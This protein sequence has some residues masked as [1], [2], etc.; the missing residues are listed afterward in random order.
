[1][2]ALLSAGGFLAPLL[3]PRKVDGVELGA[4]LRPGD[5]VHLCCGLTCLVKA[6]P[7]GKDSIRVQTHRTYVAN[8][9]A[10]GLFRPGRRRTTDRGRYVRDVW[11]V[12][13]TDF[14]G[15]LNH[16]LNGAEVGARQRKEGAVQSR[17]SRI[18]APWT[19]FDKEAA[20]SYPSVA[21][22]RRILT[23]VFRQSVDAAHEELT[24]MAMERRSLPRRRDHW[25]LPPKRKD[26][27]KLDQIGVDSAGNLVL[28]EVKEVA[29]AAP[30]EVYYAPFQLLQNVWEWHSGLDAVRGSVQELYDVGVELGMARAGAPPLRGAFDRPSGSGTTC[31]RRRCSGAT[32]RSSESR[33]RTCPVALRQ[34]RRGCC[35]RTG[36]R[37]VSTDARR[38]RCRRRD[39]RCTG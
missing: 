34:S 5:E 4:H 31:G 2:R 21:E 15:A 32:R 38:T 9:C 13:D 17:W 29:S 19:P 1:M 39:G 11:T 37:S 35:R 36:R 7:D 16:F 10:G 27:L 18:G 6:V 20:L 30:S 28:L 26:R 3:A 14:E 24:A 12:G 22:R 25:V 33:M 23:G 8:P